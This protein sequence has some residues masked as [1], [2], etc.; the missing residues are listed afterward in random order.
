MDKIQKVWERQRVYTYIRMDTY[1]AIQNGSMSFWQLYI[2]L[3]NF[4]LYPPIPK[5]NYEY[6]YYV[7]ISYLS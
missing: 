5:K 1:N 2:Y 4:G 6:I 3:Q 7:F